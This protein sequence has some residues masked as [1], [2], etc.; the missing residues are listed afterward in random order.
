M[1]KCFVIGPIGEAGS[2]IRAAADDFMEYIVRPVVTS[3]ELG[4]EA[5]RADNLNEPGRITSQIIKLL[6]DAELVVADLTT[7]NANVFYELSLRHA[8][9]KPVVHMA[10][11]GTPLSFDVR[12]NR[13]IFYTMHSRGAEQA[14]EELTKQINHVRQQGYKPM[15]P[16]LEIAAILSLEGSSI[17]EQAAIGQVLERI[18]DLNLNVS[19]I[20]QQMRME[21][22]RSN[23][24]VATIN[25]LRNEGLYRYDGITGPVLNALGP[26][27]VNALL[28]NAS[29]TSV[30]ARVLASDPNYAAATLPSDGP[31]KG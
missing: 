3:K 8:I 26:T 5:I 2:P 28:S 11:E 31:K 29:P 12:D 9:G 23:A 30:L 4:Y 13:T 17:P 21:A 16:I 24:T 19:D 14:R 6:I 15:N 10:H 27:G 20:R 25:A 7:N 18:E 1:P 22:A